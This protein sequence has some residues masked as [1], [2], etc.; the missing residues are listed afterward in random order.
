MVNLTFMPPVSAAPAGP[1][2][3]TSPFISGKVYDDA[4]LLIQEINKHAEPEGYAVVT[5]RFK[6]FKKDVNR[7]VYLRCDCEKKASL[8]STSFKRRLHNNIR[9]IEC[10]FSAVNKRNKKND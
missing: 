2:S 9:L 7:L 6:K 8:N 3:L 5:A 4:K 10:S 1:M